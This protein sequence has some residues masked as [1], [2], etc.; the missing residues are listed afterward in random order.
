MRL[1]SELA[2]GEEATIRVRVRTARVR[3][4]RRRRL[5]LLE[6]QVADDT[7]PAE[8]GVV[9]PGLP[10]RPAHGGGG[11]AAARASS[12]RGRGGATFRVVRARD[13]AGR[14]RR[15]LG[16]TRPASCPSI[17][18]PRAF[19]RGASASWPGA[20]AGS[21]ARRSSRCPAPL[22]AAAALPRRADALS[23][24]ALAVV[25]RRGSRG[26]P[27]PGA[28]GAVPVPAR[29]RDAAPHAARGGRG[30]G[31]RARPASWC[32]RWLESLPFELTEGQR[33]A[34]ARDRRRPRER[35]A[36]CSAC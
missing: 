35:A 7:G 34:V 23:R 10:R 18:P 13:P 17:R 4:T 36:R 2:I 9:Q 33:R 8:G 30:R 20:C 5:T 19:R 11:G 22:R 21:S 1:V 15:R 29:A 14:R 28:R 25:A 12:R 3:P 32:A 24:G 31:A 26:A 6:C 27:A 16:T